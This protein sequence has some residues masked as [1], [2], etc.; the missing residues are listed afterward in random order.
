MQMASPWF[1][2]G[3]GT[4]AMSS[5]SPAPCARIVRHLAGGNS[6]WYGRESEPWKIY[7]FTDRP[8]YRPKETVKLEIHRAPLQ[9]LIVFHAGRPDG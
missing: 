8:A 2:L 4:T 6:Y 1:D 3:S 5:C 7:A 9:R